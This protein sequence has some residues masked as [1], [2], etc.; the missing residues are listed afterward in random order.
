MTN[1]KDLT[2]VY[3]LLVLLAT[4]SVST[5]G[6][7]LM[8]PIREAKTVDLTEITTALSE[9]DKSIGIQI[10][11]TNKDLGILNNKVSILSVDMLDAQYDLKDIEKCAKNY[12]AGDDI[13]EFMDCLKNKL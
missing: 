5:V 7:L 9:L 10:T 3:I 1:E 6:Y 11:N 4:L 12:I 13:D 2:L 8:N